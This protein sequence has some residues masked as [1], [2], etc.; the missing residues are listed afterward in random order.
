MFPNSLSF[1]AGLQQALDIRPPWSVLRSEVRPV[2][3]ADA[4]CS[5][6]LRAL[7]LPG[8]WRGGERAAAALSLRLAGPL[9]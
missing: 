8:L 1:E 5:A 9:R 4:D 3:A 2:W 7:C 6:P